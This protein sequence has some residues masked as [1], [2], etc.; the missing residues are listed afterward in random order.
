MRQRVVARQVGVARGE[1]VERRRIPGPED[2]AALLV[3]ENDHDD[4][5]ETRH[6]GCRADETH[7]SEESREC[8]HV[9][10]RLCQKR[11]AANPSAA[12]RITAAAP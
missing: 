10:S 4:V 7:D 8:P 6:G 12:S 5:I 2:L 3:L 1:A 11:T 9:S